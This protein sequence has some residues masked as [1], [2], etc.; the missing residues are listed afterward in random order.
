MAYLMSNNTP[1]TFQTEADLS[2]ILMSLSSDS[3]VA[4]SSGNMEYIDQLSKQGE[5]MLEE[6]KDVTVPEQMLD[7]HVKALKMAK[8]AMQLKT[9]LAPSSEDPLGQI[10]SLSKAQGFFGVVISFM[11]EIQ[12][13]LL[14]YGIEEIPLNL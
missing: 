14:Q 12:Q 8:Y 1:R 9:E 3:I 13:K 6:L 2:S 7:V 4:L 5:K 11:N 10:A